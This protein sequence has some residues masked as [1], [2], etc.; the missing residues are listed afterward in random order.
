[1]NR[2]TRMDIT[3]AF[4]QLACTIGAGGPT[5]AV[6][7]LKKLRTWQ[8]LGQQVWMSGESQFG[9]KGWKIPG[10]LLGFSS[11]WKGEESWF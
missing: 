9:V 8:L 5:M 1:M 11:H 7:M 2:M 10:Q 3:K 6:C 4:I